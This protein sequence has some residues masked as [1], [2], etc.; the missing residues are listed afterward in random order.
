MLE[1][2]AWW[3]WAGLLGGCLLVVCH[4]SPS[5]IREDVRPAAG[6]AVKFSYARPAAPVNA[7]RRSGFR[8]SSQRIIGG[9][10]AAA[11]AFDFIVSV[12]QNFEGTYEHNCGGSLLMDLQTVVTAAHCVQQRGYTTPAS[13]LRVAV[14][15]SK[16]S[17]IRASNLI[18]VRR[19]TVHPRFSE[20]GN[21]PNDIALLRLERSAAGIPRVS[22]IRLPARGEADPRIG[23]ALQTAGWGVTEKGQEEASGSPTLLSTSLRVVDRERCGA[24]LSKDIP[25]SQICTG[26]AQSGTCNGDSGGPLVERRRDGPYLIGITSHGVELCHSGTADAFTKVSYYRDWIDQETAAQDDEDSERPL[27][28]PRRPFSGDHLGSCVRLA[29]MLLCRGSHIL[30]EAKECYVLAD[31]ISCPEIP[32]FPPGTPQRC[33]QYADKIY[34]L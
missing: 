21:V 2:T 6:G 23:T 30:A 8:S 9:T 13:R 17:N 18:A 4:G 32:Y 20:A 29:G 1:I 25:T 24:A 22:G 34:C 31:G 27:D 5:R 15:V 10:P 28:P 11:N 26:N 16:Q 3:R 33:L 19:I 14:G 12:Q 7:T